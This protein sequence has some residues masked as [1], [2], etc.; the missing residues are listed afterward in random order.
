M[1]IKPLTEVEKDEW[2]RQII[3]FCMQ[4]DLMFEEAGTY[5]VVKIPQYKRAK[6]AK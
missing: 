3:L 2:R 4:K 6:T 5:I 1:D